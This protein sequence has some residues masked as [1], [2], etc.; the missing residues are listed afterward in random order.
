MNFASRRLTS[1]MSSSTCFVALRTARSILTASGLEA[2]MKAVSAYPAWAI[3]GWPKMGLSLRTSH[4]WLMA[5]RMPYSSFALLAAAVMAPVFPP[6]PLMK[7]TLS[8][9]YLLREVSI[10]KITSSRVEGVRVITPGK[11]WWCAETP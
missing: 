2:S 7:T 6:W 1:W 4:Q 9:P 8:I 10:S 11:S 3:A 5:L